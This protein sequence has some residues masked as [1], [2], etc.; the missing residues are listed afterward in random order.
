[1]VLL[2]AFINALL[3]MVG[4]LVGRIFKNIPESMKST[5]L[6]IIGLAVA[7]LGIKMGF[8]SDNFIILMI[9]LV[10]GTVIGEWLDLDKQ[11]NRL[12]QWVESLFSKKRTDNNQISIAEGFV[13]ASLIFLVGSMGVIGALDSGLRND[14]NV[15]IT[16]GLIDGFISIIL[17][18]T[19]GIGVL[20]SALPVFVYQGLIALFAGVISSF[21][22]DAALQMFIH[23]MTAVGG[24]MIFAIGLNIAGLT[25]IKAANLLPGIVV[26][27]IVVAIFY[28][29]Q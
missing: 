27:G 11:M 24:V 23:E 5:V 3:I 9:S 8:E 2:G 12:G 29:F 4:A 16:K 28:I 6:S 20:L 25:K 14:H 13:T 18:S 10:V 19:L 17:T 7:L 15:L 26:V 22:P 1:M 21:I